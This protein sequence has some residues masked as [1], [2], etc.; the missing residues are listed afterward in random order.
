MDFEA[1][2][3]QRHLAQRVGQLVHTLQQQTRLKYLAI[4]SGAD[5]VNLSAREDSSQLLF[6]LAPHA[7]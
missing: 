7:G 5:L 3:T 1:H 2:L 4:R 6:N